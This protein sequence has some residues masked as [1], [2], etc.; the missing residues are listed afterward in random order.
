MT[1]NLYEIWGNGYGLHQ[2]SNPIHGY[3]FKVHTR[4]LL[5][6]I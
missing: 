2:V 1:F 3:E 6:Q 4:S 5:V